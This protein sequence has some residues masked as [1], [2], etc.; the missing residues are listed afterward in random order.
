MNK[1][2]AVVAVVG[3]FLAGC[4]HVSADGA[5]ENLDSSRSKVDHQV[6]E[7]GADLSA[8][9]GGSP[10]IAQRE[11]ALC[12]SAPVE[13]LKYVAIAE[14]TPDAEPSLDAIKDRATADGWKFE[15]TAPS[16]GDIS[17]TLYFERGRS[18]LKV[19]IDQ[20]I[21]G[22]SATGEC[23]RV[24]KEQVNNLEPPKD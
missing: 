5:L 2:I 3:L 12:G 1:R 18:S 24:T 23:I 14:F 13:A 21:I 20:G 19:N 9:L 11:Y 15:G 17:E 16:Q 8:V 4:T 10:T 6:L 7:L 22:V